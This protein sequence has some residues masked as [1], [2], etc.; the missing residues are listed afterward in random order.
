MLGHGPLLRKGNSKLQNPN[1]KQ[2]PNY[3]C[4]I[5]E[6]LI[7]ELK[8]IAEKFIIK[9]LIDSVLTIDRAQQDLRR[10]RNKKLV[11]EHT[12]LRLKQLAGTHVA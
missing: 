2:I 11:M 5:S 8:K 4:Q 7:Q 6:I 3:K 12:V 1:D 9:T 10:Y